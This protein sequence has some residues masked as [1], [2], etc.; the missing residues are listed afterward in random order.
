MRN[1]LKNCIIFHH[2]SAQAVYQMMVLAGNCGLLIFIRD[3]FKGL[4]VEITLRI[5]LFRKSDL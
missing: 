5:L 2:I 1:Y 4:S 3:C